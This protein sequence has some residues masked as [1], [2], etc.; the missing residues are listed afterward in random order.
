MECLQCLF[1]AL[2]NRWGGG[3]EGSP[4]IPKDLLKGGLSQNFV[5]GDGSGT[6]RLVSRPYY[7]LVS[8]F[9]KA[10]KGVRVG[11]ESTPQDVLLQPVGDGPIDAT[12]GGQEEFFET[13]RAFP[14]DEQQPFGAC[15]PIQD[16][17][18]TLDPIGRPPTPFVNVQTTHHQIL[19]RLPILLRQ[20]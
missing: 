10:G 14:M 18:N 4:N 16:E 20:L 12:P 15:R 1:D 19:L 9:E 13:T 5:V 6:V 2:G 11:K 17:W 3:K 7:C 8:L